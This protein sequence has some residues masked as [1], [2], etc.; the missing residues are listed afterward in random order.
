MRVHVPVQVAAVSGLMTIFKL[1][2]CAGRSVREGEREGK[3]I[4]G[5][6][7]PPQ[8][9][10]NIAYIFIL[11]KYRHQLRYQDIFHMGGICC[12]LQMK[13]IHIENF[14]H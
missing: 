9:Q 10:T 6:L 7:L 1:K 8:Q 4:H 12:V 14:H 3:V 2:I 13:Y 5:S 11:I